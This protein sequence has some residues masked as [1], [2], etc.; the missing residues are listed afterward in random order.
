MAE[1][2]Q[3]DERGAEEDSERTMVDHEQSSEAMRLDAAEDDGD[4][5]EQDAEPKAAEP[6]VAEPN[7]AEPKAAEPKAAE[8]EEV[9]AVQ[10]PAPRQAAL[11]GMRAGLDGLALGAMVTFVLVGGLLVFGFA[12]ALVPAAESQLGA[13]CRPLAPEAREGAVPELELEDLDGNPV[14]LADYAG[15]FVVV[16]FWATWCEPC[17]R[18]WPDLD[19]LA[20]RV[21]ARDD[22]AVLAISIDEQ[23]EDI[24]PYLERMGLQ[25]TAVTVL[26]AKDSS[27]HQRFGSEKI[28]DTYF[29]DRQG[30]L[31][32]VFINVREWGQAKA[33]RCVESRANSL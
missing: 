22:V 4:E 9:S 14:S 29:V 17:T 10:I 19:T 30:Q 28:P 25:N 11:R 20:A 31:D 6:K 27:A 12:Q 13:A 3:D 33:V 2:E 21:S 16:N 7:E 8:P 1:P 24:D 32:S 18:E 15:K 26:R 23:A 5:S